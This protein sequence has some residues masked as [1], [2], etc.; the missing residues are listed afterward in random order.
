MLP[1]YSPSGLHVALHGLLDEP[2]T[3]LRSL[4]LFCLL[5]SAAKWCPSQLRSVFL[6]RCSDCRKDLQH[7]V[8][9]PALF[10]VPE[11]WAR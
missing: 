1:V 11:S 6:A 2:H 4:K 10:A 7:F 8:V 5:L 9:S 3:R